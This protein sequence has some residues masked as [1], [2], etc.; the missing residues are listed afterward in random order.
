MHVDN[1][2]LLVSYWLPFSAALFDS[3][4]HQ[5]FDQS[6]TSPTVSALMSLTA[7]FLCY[8]KRSIVQSTR[9]AE[10]S[11]KKLSIIKTAGATGTLT[12]R[13]SLV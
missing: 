9:R 11:Q 8:M 3:R 5:M 10:A 12:C 6:D 2:I 7:G 4:M 13:T 1:R